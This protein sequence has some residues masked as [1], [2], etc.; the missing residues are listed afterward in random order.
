MVNIGSVAAR[1]QQGFVG[2]H[3]GYK[4]IYNSLWLSSM[5]ATMTHVGYV[6]TKRNIVV[7]GYYGA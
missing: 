3:V 4:N 1:N 7:K 5:L 6:R 2:I